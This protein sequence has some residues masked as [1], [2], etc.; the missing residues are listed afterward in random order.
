MRKLIS[1]RKLRFIV[2]TSLTLIF[3]YVAFGS[4]TWQKFVDA[5]QNF[6]VWWL[7]PLIVLN[8]STFWLRA[9]RWQLVLKPS[10]EVPVFYLFE[11]NV[12]SL[13]AN[14]ILPINIGELFR[15][16]LVKRSYSVSMFT[17]L[18]TFAIE[19]IASVLGFW[20]V[21][22]GA[23]LIVSLPP[24]LAEVRRRVLFS[25]GIASLILLLL[26]VLFLIV[27]RYR[28]G[29]NNIAQ[30]IRQKLPAKWQT[31]IDTHYHNFVQGLRFGGNRADL[32][33]IL[34]YS[35]AIRIVFGITALCAGLGFGI[36]LPLSI[37]LFLDVLVT[38]AVVLGQLIMISVG[39]YEATMTYG[40]AFFGVPEETGLSIALVVIATFLIPMF[41]L[42]CLFFLKE[43]LTLGEL[44]QLQQT[45]TDSNSLD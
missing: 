1:N 8:V 19:R 27:K 3:L 11:A 13:F 31:S 38:L 43:G 17:L 6:N 26:V 4:L 36:E 10:Q 22:I 40:L 24:E 23:V 2:A 39:P 12:L 42:G 32:V 16:Y 14:L 20:L 29:A 9:L 7:I 34:G 41:L 25:L 21:G 30:T 35:I 44:R 45:H 5:M 28:T 33:A 15:A 37:Y 18:G